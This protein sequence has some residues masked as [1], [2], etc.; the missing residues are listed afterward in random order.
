MTGKKSKQNRGLRKGQPAAGPARGTP[1]N[2][3]QDG[4][5]RQCRQLNRPGGFPFLTTVPRFPMMPVAFVS[6]PF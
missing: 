1:L 2:W 5:I 4:A 6:G 3:I